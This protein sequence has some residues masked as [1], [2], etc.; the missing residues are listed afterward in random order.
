LR[1]PRTE[2]FAPHRML[3][4]G[5]LALGW[6][7]S[8]APAQEG[9]CVRELRPRS[10][11]TEPALGVP[12]REEPEQALAA[13]DHFTAAMSGAPVRQEAMGPDPGAGNTNPLF[14]LAGERRG[15]R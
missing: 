10:A 7:P 12:G 9:G 3:V 15:E 14:P 6:F 11:R 2:V 4:V 13:P 1:G 5:P 8:E